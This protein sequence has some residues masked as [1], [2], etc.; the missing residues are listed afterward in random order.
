V[1]RVDGSNVGTIERRS[2]LKTAA[3]GA[4]VLGTTGSIVWSRAAQAATP[5]GHL[6]GDRDLHLLRRATFG[7]ND[8]SL[9]RIRRIGRDRWLDEQLR[10][11][12]IDDSACTKLVNRFPALDVSMRDKYE[13]QD[14]SWDVMFALSQATIVRAAWSERQLFE[15]MVDFWSNHLNVSNPGDHGWYNRHDYDRTV[16]RA[17]ALGRFEDMLIASAKHPAMLH[18]LNNVDSTKDN[19]N[20]N[21]G[22]ELL[23]L[24]T[25]GVDG[26]YTEE[27]MRQSALI[28]TGWGINW[29]TGLY[30]YDASNHYTGPVQVLGFSRANGSASGGEELAKDYLRYLARHR[31]T[32]EY[33]ATKLARRFVSD[34][35]PAGLVTSL[36][37]TYQA[38]QTQI[39]P[40]LRKLFRSAAFSDAIGEKVRRPYEDVIATIRALDIKA[41]KQGTDGIQGLYWVCESLGQAPLAW[42]P[43]DGYPDTAV[44]WSSAGGILDRWNT[45]MSLAAHWWPD[46]IRRPPLRSYLPR[47]LPR[48]YGE[49]VQAVA[50]RVVFVKLPAA[51]RDAICGF[52][53]HGPGDRVHEGDAIVEWRLSHLVSLLLDTPAHLLR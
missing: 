8:A 7:V 9:A 24:H 34:D 16:I 46:Q 53:D 1:A 22:R 36:A 50:K 26:G 38:N 2:F 5:E 17:H 25:V 29:N 32:A 41:D 12:S 15:V 31:K 47:D 39:V 49:L 21:Y 14:F 4:A 28:M 40:V 52:F 13:S 43:P 35:P 19:P 30:R 23:E 18:Y 33:L 20:E 10:P 37:D 3:A 6:S 48:T 11:T 44:E 45:H 42:S 51:Q 27:H